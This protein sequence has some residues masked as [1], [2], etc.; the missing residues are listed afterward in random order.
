[1]NPPLH[2]A[3]WVAEKYTRIIDAVW[4]GEH[5]LK[6]FKWH[7]SELQVWLNGTMSTFDFSELTRLVVVCHDEC[8]RAEARA[9]RGLSVLLSVRKE[10]PEA[11]HGEIDGHPKL[12]RHVEVIREMLST[13]SNE[14]MQ[15][16]YRELES[17]SG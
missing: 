3:D 14:P 10:H 17:T 4:G 2:V 7:R 8:V 11:P 13:R 5:H 12:E 1:M 9:D 6:R 15:R 16:L